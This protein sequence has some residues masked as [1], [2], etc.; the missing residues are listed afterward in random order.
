MSY[1]ATSPVP[2]IPTDNSRQRRF[3]FLWPAGCPSLRRRAGG[4][5]RVRRRQ[6]QARWDF[7]LFPGRSGCSFT[8][9]GVGSRPQREGVR[10]S[11]AQGIAAV[12]RG[13][14]SVLLAAQASA[15]KHQERKQ[16]RTRTPSATQ[17]PRPC[18]QRPEPL[19]HSMLN[20]RLS[21]KAD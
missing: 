2:T 5:V 16:A 11:F 17:P 6:T 20:S 15:V 18:F 8:A 7:T 13:S 12:L 3:P 10:Q 4:R 9:L 21:A 14:Q 1:L 19:R